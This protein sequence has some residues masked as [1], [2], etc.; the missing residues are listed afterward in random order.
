MR[1]SLMEGEVCVCVGRR[2]RESCKYDGWKISQ[3][4][5]PKLYPSKYLLE[6][7]KKPGRNQLSSLLWLS[8]PKISLSWGQT[9]PSASLQARAW[10]CCCLQLLWAWEKGVTQTQFWWKNVLCVFSLGGG[11]LII[12][13]SYLVL[14]IISLKFINRISTA[15]FF[16]ECFLMFLCQPE[17]S[18][19]LQIRAMARTW[20]Y[21]CESRLQQYLDICELCRICL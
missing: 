8:F 11:M 4:L 9:A 18:P 17:L 19:L 15:V 6:G 16:L 1:L 5:L 21:S 12:C 7:Q 2:V 3:V 13:M 14:R 20:N 10:M